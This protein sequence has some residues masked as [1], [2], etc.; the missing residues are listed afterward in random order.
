[1]KTLKT[2][3]AALFLLAGTIAMNA[4]SMSPIA[5]RNNARFLTDR[6]AYTLGITDPFLIDEIYRINYDYIWGVND[7]LDD[8]A[9][10]RF[11][12]DYLTV[13]SAR[14]MAL[15]TL[16]GNILWDRIVGYSYF[17]RP[18]VFA[19]RCWHFSIYD[20]DRHGRD[21]FF[22]VAPR[23]YHNHYAGG[24]FF[25]GMPPRKHIS[26]ARP[27]M[28]NRFDRDGHRDNG[29]PQRYD[30]PSNPRNDNPRYDHGNSRGEGRNPGGNNSGSVRGDHGNSTPS[31]VR[32]DR[33]NSRSNSNMRSSSRTSSRGASV[34]RVSNDNPSGGAVRGGRR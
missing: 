27:P 3:L 9:Y 23:P 6:M 4:Q 32:G 13:C 8:V 25:K 10:G 5:V 11:Y 7:Y 16:L 21:H 31:T 19:N 29:R 30:R 1:M 22:C 20:Y 26:P 33:G 18:I 15:R 34:T 24:H 14:D 2:L 12:N 17:H 28:N